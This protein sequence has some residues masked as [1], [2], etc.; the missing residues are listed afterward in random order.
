MTCTDGRQTTPCVRRAKPFKSVGTRGPRT[1]PA[2]YART[3]LELAYATAVHGAQGETVNRAHFALTETSTAAATYVGL[4][5]GRDSNT[6][7]I[8]AENEDAARDQWMAAFNR[9]RCDLGPAH[10]RNLALENLERHGNDWNGM[11]WT[12]GLPTTQRI[13]PNTTHISDLFLARLHELDLL[14]PRGKEEPT[15]STPS[16]PPEDNTLTSH[17]HRYRRSEPPQSHGPSI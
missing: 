8:V 5:R 14:H 1:V 7:H 15:R 17:H 13:R 2:S 16:T 12:A 3:D 11:P 6:I 10:A 9:D 4:T